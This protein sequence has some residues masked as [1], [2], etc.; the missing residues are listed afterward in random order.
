MYYAYNV[1][2]KLGSIF[3]FTSDRRPG[4]LVTIALAVIKF[5]LS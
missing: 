3:C 4:Q 5:G 2:Y 1:E